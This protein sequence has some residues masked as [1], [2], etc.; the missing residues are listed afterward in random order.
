MGKRSVRCL[1]PS[2]ILPAT[3][4]ALSQL[5]IISWFSVQGQSGKPTVSLRSNDAQ[6]LARGL[7]AM[8]RYIRID[9]IHVL[10]DD[11]DSAIC[12][13]ARKY[14]YMRDAVALRRTGAS[15][16]RRN[17]TQIPS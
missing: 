12:G 14:E 11:R 5:P 2:P 10:P 6:I 7:A 4:R 9:T 16:C 8:I 3:R 13:H 1:S 15:G 17:G